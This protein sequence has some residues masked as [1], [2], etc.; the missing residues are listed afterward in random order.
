MSERAPGLAGTGPGAPVVGPGGGGV[1]L[2]LALALG[3]LRF[4]QLGEWSLWYDEVIT[5]ADSHHGT[6]NL[7][8]PLGYL[9][10]RGTVALLGGTPDEFSL[11]FLPALLGW[12]SVPLTYWAFRPFAGGRRAGLAAL[13]V[14]LSA[15]SLYWSQNARFYTMAQVTTLIGS[16]LYLR[17]FF[18]FSLVRVL[19]G[20]LIV[21]AA[22]V[23]QLQAALLFGALVLTPWVLHLTGFKLDPRT[24]KAAL[25]LLGLAALG[26]LV[27][28]TWLFGVWATYQREKA[29][30]SI[31]GFALSTGFYVTPILGTG[32][33]VGAVQS[34]RDRDRSAVF[35]TLVVVVGVLAAIV[36]SIFARVTAQY[37][38]VLLPWIALVAAWPVGGLRAPAPRC[39]YA[40]L[41]ALPALANTGLYFSVRHGERPRWRDAYLYAWNSHEE[42][43]LVM[44]MAAAIGEYYI[45]PGHTDL[46]NPEVISWL[47]KHRGTLPAR[48]VRHDRRAWIVIQPEN[49]K[50][51]KSAD[52][53]AFRRFLQ[54]ECRLM[55]R[56]PAPAEGRDLS[57]EV[58]L[59][60]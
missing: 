46:R 57:V 7:Y 11:R 19:L 29:D 9:A 45:H 3:L 15:W 53:E 6:E 35:A 21:G 40:L 58:W 39:A 12:L 51:W 44:G 14:A 17:G 42:G 13:L 32:F 37:V 38:F 26:A 59:K 1:C 56:F 25:A 8:N 33:L 50:D 60:E 20:A 23:L 30:T 5:L 22:A 18:Q 36:L 55:R 34:F 48:W 54:E 27:R 24:R 4:F 16:G 10:I 52:R 43:D 31:V 28:V 41:L 47:D 2:A 49:L